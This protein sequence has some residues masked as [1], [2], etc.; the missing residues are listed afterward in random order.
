VSELK[1]VRAERRG[2]HEEGEGKAELII[3]IERK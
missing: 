3:I 2:W 1:R